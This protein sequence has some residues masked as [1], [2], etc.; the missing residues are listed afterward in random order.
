MATFKRKLKTF[1]FEHS[2]GLNMLSE[3][4]NVSAGVS[5]RWRI[6]NPVII[7]IIIEG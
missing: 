4:C 7:V 6:R 5:Y 2:C 1:L 3:L